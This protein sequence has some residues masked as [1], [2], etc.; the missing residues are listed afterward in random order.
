MYF[1]LPQHMA[2]LLLRS[3]CVSV[4]CR[5]RWPLA[6]LF[7]L[8]VDPYAAGRGEMREKQDGDSQEGKTLY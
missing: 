1:N 7:L 8:I 5:L 3:G 6:I 2:H 4:L